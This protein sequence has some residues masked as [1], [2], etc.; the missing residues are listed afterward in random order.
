MTT[1]NILFVTSL[2]LLELSGRYQQNPLFLVIETRLKS[3]KPTRCQILTYYLYLSLPFF[4]YS[5]LPYHQWR[6][7]EK[8]DH[9]VYTRLGIPNHD[10]NQIILS[11]RIDCLLLD[12]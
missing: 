9:N 7:Y 12:K 6:S 2:Q 10:K 11:N 3:N 4:S 1:K 5:V 8:H